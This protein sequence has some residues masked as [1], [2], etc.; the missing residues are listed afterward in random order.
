MIEMSDREF[1]EMLARGSHEALTAALVAARGELDKHVAN[2][3]DCHGG[4]EHAVFKVYS[5]LR[6]QI[7]QTLDK[8]VRGK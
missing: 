2:L 6:K 8:T 1:K 3:V 7:E 4:S 5:D